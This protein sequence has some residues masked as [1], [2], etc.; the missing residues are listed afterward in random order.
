MRPDSALVAAD[1]LLIGRKESVTTFDATGTG[2]LRL[3]DLARAMTVGTDLLPGEL[4]EA[5][6]AMA[7]PDSPVTPAEFGARALAAGGWAL[8][9]EDRPPRWNLLARYIARREARA[10]FVAIAHITGSDLLEEAAANA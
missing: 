4:I 3:I 8:E 7:E 5:G 2:R 6:S 9:L 1:H 10:V